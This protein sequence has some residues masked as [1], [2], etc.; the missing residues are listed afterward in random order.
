MSKGGAN[1]KRLKT[2]K[3][4]ETIAREERWFMAAHGTSSGDGTTERS[5]VLAFAK[6]KCILSAGLRGHL[7]EI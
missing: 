4:W 5:R 7:S 1:K 6:V 3:T 2:N